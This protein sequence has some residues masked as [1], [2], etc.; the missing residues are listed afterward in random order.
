MVG[1]TERHV[2]TR[3]G[4]HIHEQAKALRAARDVLKHDARAMLGAQHRFGGEPDILLAASA[5][6]G[7]DLVK[8]LGERKPFAQIVIGDIACKIP[9]VDHW[10]SRSFGLRRF[11]Q[12][13]KSCTAANDIERPRP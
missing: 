1:K 7:A 3:A 5:L 4:E 12:R 9:L 13:D 2:A 11:S 10:T 6:D 8:P